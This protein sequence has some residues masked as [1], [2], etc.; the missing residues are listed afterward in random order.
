MFHLVSHLH[1][2]F[3]RNER[4][5]KSIVATPGRILAKRIIYCTIYSHIEHR[6]TVRLER[7]NLTIKSGFPR[8]HSN[9]RSHV[10]N[11]TFY[12]LRWRTLYMPGIQID[13]NVNN[14]TFYLLRWR[15]SYMPC[16]QIDGNVNIGLIILIFAVVP[17][18]IVILN[19]NE[20]NA[21]S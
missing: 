2:F 18:R 14:W 9:I 5:W 11:W 10:N 21:F 8:H 19:K 20:V 17:E 13:R 1:T 4:Y 6:G 16:I 7:R 15:A 3:F 12:L